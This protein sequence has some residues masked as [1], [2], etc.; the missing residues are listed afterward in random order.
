MATINPKIT[1]GGSTESLTR[2]LDEYTAAWKA[3]LVVH[4]LDV[5]SHMTV[6]VTLSWKV[7]DTEAMFANLQALAPFTTQAHIGTVNKR[8]IASVVLCTD[9]AGMHIV[10]ILVRRPGSADA[11][12]LDSI[13][14]IV[15]DMSEIKQ[16]LTAAGANLRSEHNDMHSWLSLRFG[17]SLEFE[18][19]FVEDLVLEVAVREMEQTA[20]RL[21]HS[22]GVH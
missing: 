22:H 21:K 19:K 8:F 6:P 4:N 10:K 2:A 1:L 15:K 3:F 7:A 13:D 9:V 16:L 20:D 14:Y 17:K 5:L 18:A 11:L 12:G